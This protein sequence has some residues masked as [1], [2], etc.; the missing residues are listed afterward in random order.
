[1]NVDIYEHIYKGV[2]WAQEGWPFMSPVTS[3]PSLISPERSSS[4]V[5]TISMHISHLINP[6]I[7]TGP[8][9]LSL[10]SLFIFRS[11]TV[12]QWTPWPALPDVYEWLSKS[13][14]W[15]QKRKV[16]G[17]Q[18][19]QPYGSGHVKPASR[20]LC[21]GM[22]DTVC[23]RECGRSAA[24]IPARRRGLHLAVASVA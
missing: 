14:P 7:H 20:P 3:E 19:S 16:R 13:R 9:R 11:Q 23:A 22:E 1:M 10:L 12:L 8:F 24:S 17:T 18:V 4:S 6:F 2:F 5:V 21:T 15:R